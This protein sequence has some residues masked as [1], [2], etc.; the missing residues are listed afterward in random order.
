MLWVPV[1]RAGPSGG[2]CGR[3]GLHKHMQTS[4]DVMMGWAPCCWGHLAGVLDGE[5]IYLGSTVLIKIYPALSPT[6]RGWDGVDVSRSIWMR[7]IA[8]FLIGKHQQIWFL[9]GEED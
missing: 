4:P 9:G 2:N 5:K 3:A 6:I 1:G 7:L 8:T